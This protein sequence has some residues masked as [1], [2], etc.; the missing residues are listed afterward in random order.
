MGSI[1]VDTTGEE[2][3]G[4]ARRQKTGA[5]KFGREPEWRA[6][7]RRRDDPKV[8]ESLACF[9]TRARQRGINLLYPILDIF[10]YINLRG[11]FFPPLCNNPL[12]PTR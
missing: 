8:T 5:V 7:S 11:F 4:E 3:R 12:P 6:G 2:R 1:S 10:F 9:H